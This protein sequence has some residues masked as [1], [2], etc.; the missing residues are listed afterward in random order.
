MKHEIIMLIKQIYVDIY[1]VFFAGW[2]YG[3][4]LP[5]KKIT[6]NGEIIET[7]LP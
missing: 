4:C 1:N 7:F 2:H 5:Q 3:Y 6:E